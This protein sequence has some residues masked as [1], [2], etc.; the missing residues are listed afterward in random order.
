[1]HYHFIQK[2]HTNIDVLSR[3]QIKEKIKLFLRDKNKSSNKIY[4]T[5]HNNI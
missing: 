1:M 3:D 5:I 4:E 2:S